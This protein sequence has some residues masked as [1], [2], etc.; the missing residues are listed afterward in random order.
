MVFYCFV[1]F[2][3]GN[4]VG[5][6][7]YVDVFFF[8]G[9][10]DVLECFGYFVV[11][12]F[13]GFFDCL[14]EVVYVL[15]LFEVVDGDIIGVIEEVWDLEDVFFVEYFVGFWGDWIVGYFGDDFGFDVV[16]VFFGYDV[17][18]GVWGKD[19]DF[20]FEEF[21]VG[22]VLGFGYVFD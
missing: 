10:E 5:S 14:V 17:F 16:G 13:F 8:V 18:D 22:D 20:K 12:F 19:V 3:D 15:D 21:F 9:V 1:D 7:F 2:V 11:E 4:D 6:V